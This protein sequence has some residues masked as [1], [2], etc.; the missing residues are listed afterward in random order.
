MKKKKDQPIISGTVTDI[1]YLFFFLLTKFLK[2]VIMILRK[3]HFLSKRLIGHGLLVKVCVTENFCQLRT[4]FYPE[5]LDKHGPSLTNPFCLSSL[6]LFNCKSQ[7]K[8][9]LVLF[10]LLSIPVFHTMFW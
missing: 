2:S 7:Q 3:L 10:S 6:F 5:T 4:D 8:Q 1:R 9:L